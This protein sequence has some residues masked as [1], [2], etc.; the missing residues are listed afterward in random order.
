MRV[1]LSAGH[2]NIGQI[3]ADKGIN[4]AEFRTATGAQGTE[5]GPNEAVVERAASLLAAAGV[6]VLATDAIYHA[7]VYGEDADLCVFVHHDGTT[8]FGHDHPQ[9][10]GA[11]V[12][13]SGPSTV[14]TDD[15]AAQF[16]ATWKRI[17]PGIDG[18]TDEHVDT[19]DMLEYYGGLYRTANTPAALVECSIWGDADGERHDV[20][21]EKEGDALALA[22]ADYLGV[23]I[24]GQILPGDGAT[25]GGGT[26][27]R[28]GGGGGG[29]VDNRTWPLA[30]GAFTAS[31]LVDAGDGRGV[32]IRDNGTGLQFWIGHG[33][34]DEWLRDGDLS[35]PAGAFERALADDGAPLTVEYTAV[36]SLIRG[37]QPTTVQWFER[38]R[39]EW[40]PD[41]GVVRR[42]RVGAEAMGRFQGALPVGSGHAA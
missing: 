18:I 5:A 25:G 33:F 8:A 39:Y 27:D 29:G 22:I 4:P 31:A 10:S 16:V 14:A 7:E 1:I 32:T 23:T 26:D 41:S 12:V 19:A 11:D 35:D 40:D 6:T 21:T 15:R 36:A 2:L 20:D 38:A 28:P 9:W 3:T 37:G 34:F 42:G 13:H 30:G 24:D 17:A